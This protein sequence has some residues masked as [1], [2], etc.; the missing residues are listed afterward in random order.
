MLGREAGFIHLPRAHSPTAPAAVISPCFT[1]SFISSWSPGSSLPSCFPAAQPQPVQ[2]YGVIPPR[3]KELYGLAVLQFSG[4]S[5][6]KG[7]IWGTQQC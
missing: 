3:L 4:C 1:I 2:V 5:F 7:D 6:L